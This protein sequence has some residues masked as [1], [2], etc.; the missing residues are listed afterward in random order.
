MQ[1]STLHHYQQRAWNIIVSVLMPVLIFSFCFPST[2]V[3]QELWGLTSSGGS[4]SSGVLFQYDAATNTYTKKI[5]LSMSSGGSPQGS[6]MLASNG[7]MYGLAGGG[8]SFSGVLF[9]YD[10]ATNTYT[11]KNDFTDANGSSPQ[12]CLIE[13]A[14]GKLFGM[15]FSGGDNGF[16]VIFEYDI[17]TNTLTKK[18]D[19]SSGNGS[20]PFGSLLKASNGKLYGLTYSGGANDKGVLFEYDITSNTYTKKIDLSLAI[21]SNPTGSLIQASNGKLYGLTANGGVNDKGVLFEYDITTNTYTAK[22]EMTASDGSNPKGTLIQAGNGKLYGITNGGGANS[23]GALFEYDIAGNTYTKKVDFGGTYG[24][25]PNG[26]LMQA[27]NGKLYGMTQHGGGNEYGVLIEY[28]ISSNTCTAKIDLSSSN[29]GNPYFTHLIE[30]IPPTPEIDVTGNGNSIADGDDTPSTTDHT[31]FGTVNT[32]STL[33]RSYTIKNTGDADL[34]VSSIA[35]SGTDASM[36]TVGGI[37]L[38]ATIAANDSA[39]VTVTFTPVSGGDKTASVEMTSND[40]DEDTYTFALK[41]RGKSAPTSLDLWGMTSRSGNQDGGVIFHYNASTNTYTKMID[42]YGWIGVVPKGSLMQA[43]NGKLYGLTNW[44]G[45]S[46]GGVLFEYDFT[47]NTYT[48]KIDLNEENGN[49]PQGSLMQASNGKLYGMTYAGGSSGG[50]VLFEYDITNNTYTK[51]IDLTAN[52]GVI[53]HGGLMQASNGKLYGMTSFGGA[54]FKGVLFEYDITT[55]TYT[56]KIDLSHETGANPEGSL[57]QA[58]NGKLYG[59]T[60][61]GG[62]NAGGVLFEYDIT[63]NTYTKKIDLNYEKGSNPSGSLMQ[64]SNGKLY[65]MTAHG[66]ARRFG[67]LFE[68]DI[69]TNIYTKKDDL[70]GVPKGSLMQASNGKL[71][72]LI[73]LDGLFEYDITNNA[74]KLKVPMMVSSELGSRPTGDLIEVI[75]TEA[76]EIELEGNGVRIAD[77][78]TTPS[79]NDHTD[80]GSVSSGGGIVTRT[81]TILNTFRTPL[82]VDNITLSGTDASLFTVGGIT[83]PVAIAPNS[84]ATFTVTFTPTSTG[85]KSATVTITSN[86]EDEGTYEFSLQGR[87][88][89]FYLTTKVGNGNGSI[90]KNPDQT[91]YNEGMTVQ[92]TATPENS[93]WIFNDWSGDVPNRTTTNP[94]SVTMINDK[95]ITAYF[96]SKTMVKSLFS[97]NSNEVPPTFSSINANIQIST[98]ILNFTGLEL[99]NRS[100]TLSLL[101]TMTI[102]SIVNPGMLSFRLKAIIPGEIVISW[103]DTHK[104]TI[105]HADTSW[106]NFYLPINEEGYGKLH[107]TYLQPGSDYYFDDITITDKITLSNFTLSTSGEN[108]SVS[109]EPEQEDYS[110]GSEAI[111]S[112]TPSNKYHFTGW[113][114]DWTGTE[115]PD[116]IIMDGNKTIQAIFELDSALQTN[117]R[118]ATMR[119]W[120]TAKDA[121]KKLKAAKRKADKVFFKFNGIAD[122]TGVVLFDFGM[123]SSGTITRGKG[124]TDTLA[125]FSGV[126]KFKDTLSVSQGE[127]LQ[128][129]GISMAGK[130]MKAK[131]AWGEKGKAIA[132]TS[133]KLNRTGLPMPNLH[134]IGEEL[135]PRGFAQTSSYFANGLLLGIP[136]GE[137]KAKSILHKKYSDV[138]TSLVKQTKINK[139]DTLLTHVSRLRCFDSL[140]TKAFD[141]QQKIYPPNKYQNILYGELV[142]LKLNIAAS[143][144]EKFPVGLGELTYNDPFN[145]G[146]PFNGQLVRDIATFGDSILSCLGLTS[147]PFATTYDVVETAEK[148]NSAFTD[149]TVDTLNFISKTRL[150]GVKK[151][152]E[153]EY[154]QETPGVTPR[155][156]RYTETFQGDVPA[157]FELY[158]NYPNPFNPSTQL[159]FVIG[160]ASGGSLVTLKVYNMLGQEVATLLNNEEMDEGEYEIPFSAVD[161]ASGVYFYRINVESVDEDGLKQTFTDVKKMIYVK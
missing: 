119:E 4:N 92:I 125:M 157:S 71:Y 42:L 48:K 79:L 155:I 65:G 112:A 131:V 134:N 5:D 70:D 113:S 38:P 78:D 13:A 135:F 137:K 40:A 53:P 81:Y 118:T 63:T 100:S 86:D 161:F 83:L 93:D 104:D 142:A 1:P 57:I 51:K 87:V 60:L 6:L 143:A 140:G 126:K 59:M 152:A 62:A 31:D 147:L 139:R 49:N 43:S 106:V 24:S 8:A 68:Y 110:G 35:T 19:L 46:D 14:S 45:S 54:Y 33:V 123:S 88:G 90:T 160:S 22:I 82:N 58:S 84:S 128:V 107:F 98:G 156:A 80:F 2:T 101:P 99:S 141:K 122:S 26:S 7:K 124:K 39:T 114:G 102:D 34:F 64:A 12:G 16:G 89:V 85:I 21:G 121:G 56:K 30:N 28:D 159:S 111:I 109:I 55:N 158:Q 11:K 76:P 27:S 149:G 145:P 127:T 129:D 3:A 44:G 103:N 95:T 132:V 25:Y 94:L 136:Q 29:G 18:I 97:F 75:V 153:V 105:Y 50:G 74:Y 77:G 66:G 15:T 37:T 72:G 36:F 20:Y 144:T 130:L 120:A 151:L 41:G 108:G 61:Y 32:G 47:N 17:S 10:A 150:T 69:T 154:L 52:E 133:Y 138:L 67:V 91:L 23:V 146:N 148:I 73:D 9:E 115:N 116:T 96:A 117:Y